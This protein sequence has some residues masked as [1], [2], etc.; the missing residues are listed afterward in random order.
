MKEG[1]G[2]EEVGEMEEG[3]I[4]EKGAGM[5]EG[6]NVEEVGGGV[7]ADVVKYAGQMG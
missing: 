2:V 3:G 7:S 1:G 6:G 5:E 4:I